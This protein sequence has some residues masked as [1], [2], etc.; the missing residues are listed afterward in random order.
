MS[1]E[2][3]IFYPDNKYNPWKSGHESAR[4]IEEELRNAE[5]DN[6]PDIYLDLKDPNSGLKERGTS[7]NKN[8][9]LE[10]KVRQKHLEGIEY[11]EKCM[12]TKIRD[13]S[14]KD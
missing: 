10:L 1:W 14:G 5:I 11:W 3:R 13:S 9:K 2:W 4:Q 6:R 7:N 8:P 12:S